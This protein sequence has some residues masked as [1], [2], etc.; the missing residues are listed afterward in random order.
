[1]VCCVNHEDDTINSAAVFTPCFSSLEMASQIVGIEPDISNS[2]FGLMRMH[3]TVCLCESVALQHVEERSLPSVIKT[4]EDDICRL[5]K[6]A[7]PLE[8]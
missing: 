1:M 4:K 5:L 6:K 7:E 3:S 8:G 2:H